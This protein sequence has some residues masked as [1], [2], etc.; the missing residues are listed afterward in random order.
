MMTHITVAYDEY[1]D[2]IFFL[3]HNQS[4][5]NQVWFTYQLQGPKSYDGDGVQITKDFCEKYAQKCI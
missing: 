4:Q 3:C 5:L 2:E 1:S